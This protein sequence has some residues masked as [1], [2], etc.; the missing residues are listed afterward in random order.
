MSE[1]RLREAL[2]FAASVIKSGEPWTAECERIIGAALAAP[3]EGRPKRAWA[4]R[5]LLLQC[6][7][8]RERSL[9][10]DAYDSGSHFGGVAP[11]TA[12]ASP[13][14]RERDP[15]PLLDKHADKAMGYLRENRR[16]G[17]DDTD[18][19]TRTVI[20]NQMSA[21][22]S[23]WRAASPEPR[24]Y[25]PVGAVSSEDLASGSKL[26]RV[27]DQ[28]INE[29]TAIGLDL[30][31]DL[32]ASWWDDGE[33]TPK[34]FA[35]QQ[36]AEVVMLRSRAKKMRER[37]ASPEPEGTRAPPDRRVF[38][39]V[40][41]DEERYTGD[42]DTREEAIAAAPIE[43][44]LQP[45]DS[46]WIGRGSLYE[47]TDVD[48]DGLFERLSEQAGEDCG[49]VA[50]EWQPA[51]D[52]ECEGEVLA[53]VL[54]CL[55]R[56][57]DIPEFWTVDDIEKH[58]APASPPSPAPPTCAALGPPEPGRMADWKAD[59]FAAPS[60]APEPA[61]PMWCECPKGPHS[62]ATMCC[63]VCKGLP[64]DVHKRA[65]AASSPAP[66]EEP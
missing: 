32:L 6:D 8:E 13:E 50:E 61:E 23:D 27:G 49:E 30:A 35:P 54:R 1:Y 47:V 62:R 36:A 22:L 5:T 10:L 42:F 60:P 66:K 16:S 18:D 7:N 53:A 55:A 11:R 44:G 59:D 38:W 31:A 39:S 56:Q 26:R 52:E 21:L 58:R 4:L 3:D 12:P 34:G 46:F 57:K 43:L 33:Q 48:V 45:G 65:P 64:K 17:T 9:V 29:A 41:S 25:V 19:D 51:P 14:P 40:S 37:A 2:A 24:V 63:P 28:T 20:W 15:I